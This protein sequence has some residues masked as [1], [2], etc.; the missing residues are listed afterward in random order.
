MR[1]LREG[2]G[3]F[4]EKLT[5][6]GFIFN[7]ERLVQ[8]RKELSGQRVIFI[9][10]NGVL[11]SDKRDDFFVNPQAEE[12][13]ASLADQGF[14][15][16]L[17]TSANRQILKKLQRGGISLDLFSMI[18]TA[19]D[20]IR[21]SD[22]KRDIFQRVAR[23]HSERLGPEADSIDH[24]PASTKTPTLLCDSPFYFIDDSCSYL[25]R[26]GIPEEM[27]INLGAFGS[28]NIL[29]KTIFGPEVLKIIE[30]RNIF[31]ETE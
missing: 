26:H 3:W 19:E 1:F 6:A 27:I 20:Y 9:D 2:L 13:L 17:W 30:A 5:T 24:I 29:R 18:I 31:A 4:K 21:D 11:C 10:A 12:V 28:D 16:V 7:E 23:K 15:L 22:K 14:Y 8:I 25:Q